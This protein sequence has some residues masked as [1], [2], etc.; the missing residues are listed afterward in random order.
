MPP[1]SVLAWWVSIIVR[2]NLLRSLRWWHLCPHQGEGTHR[3][4]CQLLF[5]EA[6]EHQVYLRGRSKQHPSLL[7]RQRV[8]GKWQILVHCPQ[9][10]YFLWS[11]HELSIVYAWYIQERFDFNTFVS[12]IHDKFLLPI[13]PQWDWELKTNLCQKCLPLQ[14]HR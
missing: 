2:T 6:P 8:S 7:R 3:S 1:W 9:K 11:V 10:R 5:F 4:A 14:V 13:P 12:G